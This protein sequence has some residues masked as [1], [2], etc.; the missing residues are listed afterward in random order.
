MHE[1]GRL[2]AVLAAMTLLLAS[3]GCSASS[4]ATRRGVEVDFVN[5][6]ASDLTFLDSPLGK[7]IKL[8]GCVPVDTCKPSEGSPSGGS[9]GW[10][11]TRKLPHIFRLSLNDKPLM[12]PAATPPPTVWN[13][14]YAVVYQVTAA[15]RCLIVQHQPLN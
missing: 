11:E 5:G 12:C 13:G 1:L 14:P 7:S 3:E 6:N 2:A 4:T 15:G 8:P 10:T 9:V